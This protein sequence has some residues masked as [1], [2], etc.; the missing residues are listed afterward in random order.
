MFSGPIIPGFS[1]SGD[2]ESVTPRFMRSTTADGFWEIQNIT[3]PNIKDTHVIMGSNDSFKV[4]TTGGLTGF[5]LYSGGIGRLRYDSGLKYAVSFRFECDDS[6]EPF[7]IG[8]QNG[9]LSLAAAAD[10]ID[11][12]VNSVNGTLKVLIGGA[13]GDTNLYAGI[14]GDVSGPGQF[15]SFGARNAS[16][17]KYDCVIVV[18]PNAQTAD[19]TINGVTQQLS[20]ADVPSSSAVD[21]NFRTDCGGATSTIRAFK[22][23]L[24]NWEI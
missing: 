4:N 9:A 8:Y 16:L 21:V 13:S 15:V 23:P 24:F 14:Q 10:G 1:P 3:N 20:G 22:Q 7:S 2:Y 12:I 17:T 18:D 5:P 6:T 19:F 11:D